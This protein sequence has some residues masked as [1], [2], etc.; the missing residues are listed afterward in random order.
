VICEKTL[1]RLIRLPHVDFAPRPASSNAC[2]LF[3]KHRADR[4]EHKNT[5]AEA[6][7]EQEQPNA[8][9]LLDRDLGRAVGVGVGPGLLFNRHAMR[10]VVLPPQHQAAVY[11]TCN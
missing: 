2:I 1:Q 10:L 9:V 7:R 6:R 5:R 4:P 3:N 11:E 8:G